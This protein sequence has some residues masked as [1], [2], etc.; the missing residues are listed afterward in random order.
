MFASLVQQSPELNTYTGYAPP[1]PPHPTG[2]FPRYGVLVTFE[3]IL[4]WPTPPML[5]SVPFNAKP[6]FPTPDMGSLR[7]F[8]PEFVFRFKVAI[9]IA[10]NGGRCIYVYRIYNVVFLL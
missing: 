1:L 2:V 3:T 9:D 4:N 7:G 6:L 10:M 5:R 8:P